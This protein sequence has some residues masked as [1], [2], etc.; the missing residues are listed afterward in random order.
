MTTNFFSRG[1]FFLPSNII[2]LPNGCFLIRNSTRRFPLIPTPTPTPTPPP[3]PVLPCPVTS[4]NFRTQT[5]LGVGAFNTGTLPADV[6]VVRITAVGARGG[7]SNSGATGGVGATV[8]VTINVP[9]SATISGVIGGAGISGV[10]LNGGAGGSNGGGAG[11]NGNSASGG[12]GGGGQTQVSVNGGLPIIIA[13]GGGGAGGGD[14]DNIGGNGGEN[15]EDGI[16]DN[17]PAQGGTQLAG[18]AGGICAVSGTAGS[19]NT[20][21]PGASGSEI[22]HPGGGGGGAGLF[23]GG[24]GASGNPPCGGG[25]GGGSSRTPAGAVFSAVPNTNSGNGSVIIQYCSATAPPSPIP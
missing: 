13:A 6:T 25:G 12:G 17:T 3:P 19:A 11:G 7:N 2:S 18:G 23:G 15:G 1:S 14:E 8:V 16:G 4:P 5:F 20:G 22:G 9:P 21:G 24:G 10:G